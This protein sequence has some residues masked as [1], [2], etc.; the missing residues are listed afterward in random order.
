[1]RLHGCNKLST[2][3]G[4]LLLGDSMT[5]MIFISLPVTNVAKSSAFY[6]ALGAK[7]NPDFRD[8]SACSLE[9]NENIH[10]MI[11]SHEKWTSFT[12]RKIPNAHETAQMGLKIT[13][14]S[15]NIVDEI[16]L[17][18]AAVGGAL[19]V[20]PIEDFPFMYC[21]DLADPDGH[22]W[23]V[24]WYDP[25]AMAGAGDDAVSESG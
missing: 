9:F 2:R 10:L 12:A 3:L 1:M 17:A 22:I 25:A 7:I 14:E 15:R 19:D 13:V 20:N 4:A 21:R 23:G 24:M 11:L 5:R 8:E 6:Q 18:C 16:A